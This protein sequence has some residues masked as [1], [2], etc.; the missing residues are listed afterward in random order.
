VGSVVIEADSPQVGAGWC[1][2]VLLIGLLMGYWMVSGTDC[3]VVSAGRW[4]LLIAGWWVL[5]AG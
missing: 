5:G 3:W 2:W 1:W 4:V